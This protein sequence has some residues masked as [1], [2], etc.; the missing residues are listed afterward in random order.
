MARLILHP[1]DI[2]WQRSWLLVIQWTKVSFK[3]GYINFVDV[4]L[5]KKIMLR[6]KWPNFHVSVDIFDLFITSAA[7]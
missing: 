7:S 6:E 4:Q 3:L 1:F 2:I 5:K